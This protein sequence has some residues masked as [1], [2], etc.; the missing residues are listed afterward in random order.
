MAK[1]RSDDI[2]KYIKDL[3]SEIFD[4]YQRVLKQFMNKL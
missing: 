1:I 3:V 4:G 2:Q